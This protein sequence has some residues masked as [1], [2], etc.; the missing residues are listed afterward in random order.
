MHILVL[1]QHLPEIVDAVLEVLPAVCIFTMNV[2]VAI[3]IFQL[4]LH[5]LL[6]Q[7]NDSFS[8]LF[9]IT[10]AMH[11]VKHVILELLF[12]NLLH[13]DFNSQIGD[14]ICQ[15]LLP[16]PEIIHNQR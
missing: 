13:I 5:V 12:E 3:L 2:E 16:H 7:A 15:S 6:V 8:E 4:F 14:F 9:E 11:H 10:E 1:L